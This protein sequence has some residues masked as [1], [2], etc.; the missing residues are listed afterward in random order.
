MNTI[1]IFKAGLIAP[2]LAI[3]L[4][5]CATW[6]NTQKGGAIGAG[7]GATVG[8]VIGKS[9]GN[10]AAGAI[11]GATVGG[12]AGA[13]IG[14]QMDKQAEELESDLEDAEVKRVGEGIQITFDSGILFAYDSYDLSAS[15]KQ[16]LQEMAGT[17]KKYPDTDI[18]IAGHTDSKGGE[19]YNETLSLQ[20]A[21]SVFSYLNDLGVATRRLETVGY[22]E[23]SPVATNETA[24]GRAKN[25]RVEVAIYANEEMKRKAEEGAL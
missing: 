22:G 5:G 1:K 2:M 12:A 9:T 16:N 14:R 20:R 18:L 3:L 21:N 19:S 7:T 4:S 15:S 24:A 6:S 13:L 8:G 11:I 23:T 10:T 25:R 17:L